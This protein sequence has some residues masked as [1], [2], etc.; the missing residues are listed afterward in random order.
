MPPLSTRLPRRLCLCNDNPLTTVYIQLDRCKAAAE[1]QHIY[2]EWVTLVPGDVEGNKFMFN[3]NTS[4]KHS[5]LKQMACILL[6]FLQSPPQDLVM[7][8]L[9][10]QR[11]NLLD[12]VLHRSRCA[13][14]DLLSLF[15]SSSAFEVQFP[16]LLNTAGQLGV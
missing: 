1:G 2:R 11:P 4:P 12:L 8:P 5:A 16:H 13:L 14:G 15:L 10:V 3:E 9:T 6:Y 7:S